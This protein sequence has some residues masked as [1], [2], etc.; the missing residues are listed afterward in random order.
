AQGDFIVTVIS[1]KYLRSEY[2]MYELFRIYRNCADKPE[3]FLGKVVPLILPDAKLER[4]SDRFERAEYWMEQ[5]KELEPR[6]KEH[7]DAVGTQFYWKFR[8]IGEFARNTADMLEHLVDKLQPRDFE[9]QAKEGF[10]E[11]LVQIG[12]AHDF[13]VGTIDK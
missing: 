5:Q 7:M 6:V 11:V 8:L 12:K 3:R 13:S 4:L 1:D 2:C 10:R 9:R